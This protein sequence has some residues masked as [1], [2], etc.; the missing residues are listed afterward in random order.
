MWTNQ[1]GDDSGTVNCFEMKRGEPQSIFSFNFGH[2]GLGTSGSGGGGGVGSVGG[3]G[4]ITALTMGGLTGGAG[5]GDR[6]FITQVSIS[7]SSKNSTSW[8]IS[9]RI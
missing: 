6:V 9:S 3:M 1:V 2:I 5:G 8:Y 4:M 7:W